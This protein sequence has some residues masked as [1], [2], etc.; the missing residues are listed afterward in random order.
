V[1]KTGGT[2]SCPSDD[3]PR[4][5]EGAKANDRGD[6]TEDEDGDGARYDG[7]DIADAFLGL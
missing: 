4:P 7:E 1:A 3:H 2:S 6:D 5:R